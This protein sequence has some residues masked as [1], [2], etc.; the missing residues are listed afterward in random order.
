MFVNY[1][2]ILDIRIFKEEEVAAEL[3]SCIE[4]YL[5]L[6]DEINRMLD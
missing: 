3:G 1:N 6:I 2:I 4:L 5:P